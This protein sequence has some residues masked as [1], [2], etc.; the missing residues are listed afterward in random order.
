[1]Y[2][3]ADVAASLRLRRARIAL[4][5]ALFSVLIGSAAVAQPAAKGVGQQ[6]AMEGLSGKV[7][8]CSGCHGL[9]GE[10]SAA[11]PYLR[12]TGQDYLMAQ[13][14]AFANGT[15]KNSLMQPIAQG[16]TKAQRSAVASYYS[17]LAPPARMV[18]APAADPARPGEWLARRGRWTEDLP[19]C[20]Q[21]HGADGGGVGSHVPPLAGLPQAYIAEQLQAWKSGSRPAGPLALMA[22]VATKLSEADI[23]AAS[24]YYAH[25]GTDPAL[26]PPTIE[27]R[28]GK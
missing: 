5:C 3:H 27:G 23:L 14:D 17:R 13:L 8:A 15:R 1:M 4:C 9:K 21:C 7:A 12:G 10:G 16:L 11:F 24:T 22:G 20:A 18:V 19:G 6:I 25:M 26:A 2:P 28:A